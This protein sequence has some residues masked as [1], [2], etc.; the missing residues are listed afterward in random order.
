[1][2]DN[3]EYILILPSQAPIYYSTRA[4]LVEALRRL[5]PPQ[6][7]VRILGQS[8]PDHDDDAELHDSSQ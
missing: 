7:E 2:E 3:R 5:A 6:W 1:M 8:S 4:D